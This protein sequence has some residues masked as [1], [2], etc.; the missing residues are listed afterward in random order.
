MM[1]SNLVDRNKEDILQAKPA[2]GTME[3]MG[4]RDMEYIDHIK[5]K[6]EIE[7]YFRKNKYFYDVM[8]FGV[9]DDYTDFGKAVTHDEAGEKRYELFTENRD[10][11]K[12]IEVWIIKGDFDKKSADTFIKKWNKK[13]EEM[14]TL[15]ENEEVLRGAV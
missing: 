15:S 14:V 7:T 4:I 3:T 5:G 10:T 1:I 11:K 9:Y 2:E 6:K 13:N 12:I 8:A